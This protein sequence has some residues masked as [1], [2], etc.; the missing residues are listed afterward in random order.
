[1]AEFKVFLTEEPTGE[2]ASSANSSWVI[3]RVEARTYLAARD[4]PP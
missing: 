1:L 3:S 4:A 2:R